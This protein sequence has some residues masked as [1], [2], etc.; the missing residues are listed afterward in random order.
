MTMKNLLENDFISR[1]GLT[2]SVT[3]NVV[4]TNAADFDLIDDATLLYPPGKGIAQYS[5]P[6]HKEV[7]VLNYERFINSLP[8]T[9]QNGRKKCDLIVYTSDS[10]F[11]LLNELTETQRQ[12]VSNFTQQDGTQRVGKRNKAISQ[13][14]QTLKDISDVPAIDA[15]IKQ[16]KTKHC[17]F[18]NKPPLPPAGITA[19]AAFSRLSLLTPYGFS[20]PNADI[21]SYGFEFW[22][23]SSHQTYLL[24]IK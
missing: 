22:E 6:T 18:F 14:K 5:N 16:H 3:V 23:F 21:E 17:C 19:P 1:Y 15:F 24:S 8:P 13:L 10:S 20:S 2:A 12:Y 7:H 4:S 9:F 11:F